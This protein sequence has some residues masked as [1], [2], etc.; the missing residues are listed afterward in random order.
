VGLT[1][2]VVNVAVLALFITSAS[3]RWDDPAAPQTLAHA[4]AFTGLALALLGGWLGGELVS[5]LGVGVHEGA[6]LNCPNSLS[7]R[8]AGEQNSE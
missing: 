2:G 6:H 8:P 4:A 3:L 5:R 7:G 1:H